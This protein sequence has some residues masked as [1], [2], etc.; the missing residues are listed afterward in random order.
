MY[1]SS[2]SST[3]GEDSCDSDRFIRPPR[4]ASLEIV[5]AFGAD[6]NPSSFMSI[7]MILSL[8]LALGNNG[9]L[10]FVIF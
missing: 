4:L 2:K 9:M 7:N 8:G 1:N 6:S 10:I 5:S 3:A